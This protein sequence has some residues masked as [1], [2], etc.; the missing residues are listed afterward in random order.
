M[1]TL[2]GPIGRR[3]RWHKILSRFDLTVGYIPGKENDIADI[4]SRWAYPASQAFR[5]ISVHGNIHDVEEAEKIL[6]QEKIDE[7]DCMAIAFRKLPKPVKESTE[8]RQAISH[9]QGQ[10]HQKVPKA[11]KAKVLKEVCK[12]SQLSKKKLSSVLGKKGA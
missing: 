5:D 7:K 1:D 4:L 2:S 11:R 9:H 6:R 10:K 8:K 12:C 3:A